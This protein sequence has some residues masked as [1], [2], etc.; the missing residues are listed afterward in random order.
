MMEQ[1]LENFETWLTIWMAANLA[2]FREGDDLS[3]WVRKPCGGAE[4]Y[5]RR[6]LKDAER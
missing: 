5:V 6:K 2:S 4:G 3:I 1:Q